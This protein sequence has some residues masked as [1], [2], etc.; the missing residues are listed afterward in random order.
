MVQILAIKADYFISEQNTP[1]NLL[2]GHL[3]INSY[4]NKFTE[5]EYILTHD[6]M[7]VL[8][9]T[10]T[11][12]DSSFTNDQ[13]HIKDFK[14]HRSD[15]NCHGGGILAYI[16]SDLP[17]RRRCDLE[18]L[19][20]SPIESLVLE[21]YI[22]KEKRLFICMYS[23][24]TKYKH[25][26]CDV[27]DSLLDTARFNAISNIHV[28][29][30]L[31]INLL[32]TIESKCLDVVIETHGLKNVITEPTC[33][34]STNATL[35]DVILTSN[36]RRISGT[37]NTDI[38]LSDYHNL[39][40]FS[41][42]LHLPRLAQKVISYPSYKH[43]DEEIYKRDISFAPF[44]VGYIFDEFDDTFW[45][46]QTLLSN[47]VDS[48]APV[49]RKRT[50]KKPL[51]CM[52][53]RLRKECHRKSMLRNKYFKYRSKQA[54]GNYRKSRNKVSNL[55]A[56]SMHSYFKTRCNSHNLTNNPSEYWNTIKPFMS[57]KYK[58]KGSAITLSISL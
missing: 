58:S 30:D 21:M 43:F 25:I 1:K 51:P 33:H 31:N 9:V 57:D 18:D 29:A 32:N 26:C 19:V 13:F 23:L 15:R 35:I 45:F 17:H 10:E 55:K 37:L 6:L 44:H 24:N 20:C 12:I 34:K 48:H 53:S 47:I 28:L 8:F 2:C 56:V 38:G 42:K 16:R 52:N 41:T 27:L 5:I 22:R 50:V 46:N 3:N 54:W 39:V 4:R 7:D 36:C 11:K 40:A 14:L 49:K